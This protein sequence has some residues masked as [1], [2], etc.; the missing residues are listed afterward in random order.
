MRTVS[1][2]YDLVAHRCI[3]VLKL[4]RYLKNIT[5]AI[6][7]ACV[8]REMQKHRQ[9]GMAWHGVGGMILTITEDNI[10]LF[11]TS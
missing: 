11:D 9:V 7:M 1:N 4:L 8:D 10:V 5:L 2:M 6:L 3:H